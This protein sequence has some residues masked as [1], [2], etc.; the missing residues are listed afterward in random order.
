MLSVE[1]SLKQINQTIKQMINDC[2][3]ASGDMKLI[4]SPNPPIPLSPNDYEDL[5]DKLVYETLN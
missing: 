5:S 4:I 1:E 3:R 2:Y